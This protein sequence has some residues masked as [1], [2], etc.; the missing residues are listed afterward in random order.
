MP[1]AVPWA[2]SPTAGRQHTTVGL[3][4]GT[5]P[6]SGASTITATL[7][8]SPASQCSLC[9]RSV[10][11]SGVLTATL[12]HRSG[13]AGFSVYPSFF[14]RNRSSPSGDSSKGSSSSKALMAKS[15]RTGTMAPADMPF[16]TF[17]TSGQRGLGRDEVG[18]QQVL[19]RS[20]DTPRRSR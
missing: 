8:T 6:S 13:V 2:F 15:S 18:R 4:M 19:S 17:I 12:E 9:A 3:A 10:P 5:R 7:S 1:C 11:P 14:W 16:R 20:D